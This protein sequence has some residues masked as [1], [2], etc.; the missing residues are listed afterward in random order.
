MAVEIHRF[1]SKPE[2]TP[3]KR[4]QNLENKGAVHTD[5]SWCFILLFQV[6]QLR[7]L[8]QGD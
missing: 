5:L 6:T 4:L 2:D 1:Q 8:P 3:S 7:H